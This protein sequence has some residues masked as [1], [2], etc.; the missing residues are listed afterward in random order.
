MRLA[1]FVAPLSAALALSCSSTPP[2][3]STPT[4]HPSASA[5]VASASAQPGPAYDLSP[6]D[7][8]KNQVVSLHAKS[9]SSTL[10]K[11][12][13]DTDTLLKRLFAQVAGKNGLRMDVAPEKLASMVAP[14][15]PIDA[16]VTLPD[17][18]GFEPSIAVAIGLR[19]L[20]DAKAAFNATEELQGGM[21]LFGG[22][23]AKVTC[24]VAAATGLVPARMIC[25]PG[26]HD[27]EALGPYLARGASSIPSTTDATI[28]VDFT[29]LNA[30]FGS[31]LAS[32]INFAPTF[33]KSRI[34]ISDPALDKVLDAVG[35][36]LGNEAVALLG[37]LDKLHVDLGVTAADGVTLAGTLAFR[38]NKSWVATTGAKSKNEAAPP[39]FARL[40]I[41]VAE[42]SYSRL[43]DPADW[44]GI[45]KTLKD[46]LESFLAASKV[47]T[48]AE[49]KKV[50]ALLDFPL[51]PNLAFVSGSG[52]RHAG[53]A[54]PRKTDDEKIIAAN[55]AQF[56]YRL[57]GFGEKADALTKW[58]KEAVAAYNQAGIQK[59]LTKL[60]SNL[61]TIKTP[62]PPA[63]L[64]KGAYELDVEIKIAGDKKRVLT[65]YAL[66]MADGDDSWLAIGTSKD[67][68]LTRLEMVKNGAPAEKTLAQKSGF[69]V[70]AKHTMAGF[71][72]LES[73]RGLGLN[74]LANINA[75]GQTNPVDG[76][77]DASD[78]LDKL[79]E[80]LPNKGASPMQYG[81]TVTSTSPLVSSFILNIPK[82]T[83]ADAKALID[84]AAAKQ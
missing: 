14:E 20:E 54:L 62:T 10:S 31:L 49:R 6:V 78:S 16:I 67:E 1:R 69:D 64:G 82:G 5:P 36:G 17:K 58:L 2:Q 68:L 73:L 51:V 4:A 84:S 23:K 83:V 13:V 47:G 28:D 19:S 25:G 3:Q 70:T 45:K 38:D 42:A 71:W 53:K 75:K 57:Y 76:L 43:N 80:G 60:S 65:F 77:L 50:S 59:E 35:I 11:L 40:P 30:K 34:G 41:D 74:V 18:K 52:T 15:A 39:A 63:S 8:P 32:K 27:L 7:A 66:V 29:I 55:D 72:T 37:D 44:E 79:F 24:V 9:L 12:G 26:E 46:G 33:L 61:P 22:N 48:D 81:V 56:G 21:W